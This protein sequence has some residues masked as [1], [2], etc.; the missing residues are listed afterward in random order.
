MD[1][2]RHILLR[3]NILR[4]VLL[5]GRMWTTDPFFIGLALF[6]SVIYDIWK[7]E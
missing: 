3:I 6:Q 4:L 2:S 5:V 7:L 1:S